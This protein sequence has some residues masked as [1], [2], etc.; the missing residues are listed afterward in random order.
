MNTG[1]TVFSQIMDWT[2]DSVKIASVIRQL[3]QYY[4]P[5][6]GEY[7]GILFVHRTDCTTEE[8]ILII[9]H[10]IGENGLSRADIGSSVNKDSSA[11]SR[12]LTKLCSNKVREVIKLRSG[13]FRLT[14]IGIRRVLNELGDKLSA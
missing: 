1:R 6:I 10:H 8:E 12:A 11:I 9:L 2:G 14:N 5:I 7:E 3:V 13:N 4:I